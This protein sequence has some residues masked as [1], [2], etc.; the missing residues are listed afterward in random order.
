LALRRFG[1]KVWLARI[2]I[3]WGI[4]AACFALVQ[5]ETSFVV[6]R[7]LLGVT[8][9]G[10]FPGV[11]MYLAAWFPNKV[12]VRLFAIFYLAQP[13]S[14]M[15]GGPLSGWL[16]SLGEDLGGIQGWQLMFLVQGLLAVAAGVAAYF[17][18]T[19][20]PEEATF[21]NDEEKRALAEITSLEDAV[22]TETGPQGVLAAL[23]HG[24]VW[25]FTVIYFCLQVAVYGVTFY[26][27]QQVSQLKASGVSLDRRRRVLTDTGSPFT[28]SS[29][30]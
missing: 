19:N 23:R 22:K 8:E 13:F 14:Q 26:L 1:A 10:L 4:V 24:K 29:T 17:L 18:L 2:A 6:L 16:I 27:P 30:S 9:A 28:S 7:F 25:Y 11:I 15:I 21:L 12:R 5:G 20:G 3:T